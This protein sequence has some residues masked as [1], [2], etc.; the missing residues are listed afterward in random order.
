MTEV[1]EK[2]Q[3]WSDIELA[4]SSP[5]NTID[6]GTMFHYASFFAQKVK[7]TTETQLVDRIVLAMSEHHSGG[8]TEA[9]KIAQAIAK[10]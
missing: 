2:L 8:A 7:T 10:L 5:D 3:E 1:K 4:Y 6:I 9:L